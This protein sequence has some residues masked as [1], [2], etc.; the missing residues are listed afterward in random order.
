M[1]RKTR[2]WKDRLNDSGQVELQL[3]SLEKIDKGKQDFD[4]GEISRWYLYD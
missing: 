1:A 2:E 3:S 4:V